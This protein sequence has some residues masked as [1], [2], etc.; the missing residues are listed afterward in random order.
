MTMANAR[1]EVWQGMML[2]AA[3]QHQMVKL[4]RTL[5]VDGSE[6]HSELHRLA[7]AWEEID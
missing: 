1:E 4:V 5:P 7:D 6:T 2:R 3:I